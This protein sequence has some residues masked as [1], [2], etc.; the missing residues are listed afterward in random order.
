MSEN[1]SS[2]QSEPPPEGEPR[3][4][5]EL[6]NRVIGGDREALAELF[7]FYRPRLWRIVHFRMHPRL[8]GRIDADDVLQDA[9]LKAESR[10]KYFLSDA[11]RSCFIWFRMITTQALIELHRKH[12]GADKRSANR[13]RSIHAKWNAEDTS[14][15]MT[16][17]LL[18]SLT[19]P[20]SALLRAEQSRQLD[21][22]IQTL[23]ELDREILALRHFEEL[24]NHEAALVLGVSEQA[25][26]ARYV[27]ALQRLKRVME[28]LPTLAEERL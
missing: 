3:N 7:A 27:R 6:V 15:C 28:T 23:S 2:A 22:A 16:F 8:Q 14:S 10:I 21:T 4:F 17:H 5:R 19:S 20:S 11:S 9:W 12:L 24:T 26:S 18:G 13:E 25:A 1:L